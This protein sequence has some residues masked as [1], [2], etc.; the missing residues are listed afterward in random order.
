LR[1]EA[2]LIATVENEKRFSDAEALRALLAADAA[3][4]ARIARLRSAFSAD[5]PEATEADFER[6]LP[7]L[8]SADRTITGDN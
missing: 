3:A 5:F 7:A 1:D 6:E 2:R 8:I 4:S